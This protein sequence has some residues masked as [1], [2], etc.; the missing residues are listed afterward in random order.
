MDVVVTGS[1]G[2]IGNGPARRFDGRRPPGHPARAGRGQGQ[3]LR[4]DPTAGTI[5]AAGLEGVDAVVHLAGAG[6]ADHRWSDD[7]KAEI[8]NSRR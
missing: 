2:L 4:W 3:P 6:I 5:D 8:L 7:Y 1:S